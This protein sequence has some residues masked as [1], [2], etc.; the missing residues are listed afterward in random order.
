MIRLITLDAF[1]TLLTVR[2][3]VG[4]I[5]SKTAKQH[6]LCINP[7]LLDSQY[8]KIYK[9]YYKKYPN[10]GVQNNISTQCFW[11]KIVHTTFKNSG[12]EDDDL[13][14]N[15]ASSLYQDFRLPENWQLFDDVHPVL[16]LLKNTGYKL[17]VVSN[18]DERLPAILQGLDVLKYF[19]FVLCSTEVKV[20]KPSPKIF[21][22]A[23][24]HGEVKAYQALHVGDS[25]VKDYNAA[26][27]IGMKAYVID[28]FFNFTLE[29]NSVVDPNHVITSLKPLHVLH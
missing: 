15:I 18:F 22:L 11:H 4:Q 13:I 1:N 6:G 3:S 19:S 10:F 24:Q 29:D 28:R 16:D 2:G 8:K 20:A 5:Y 9:N 27:A 21:Q 25:V 23:L 14:S 12:C 7:M 17:G 26:K